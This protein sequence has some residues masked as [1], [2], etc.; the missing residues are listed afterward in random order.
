MILAASLLAYAGV[1]AMFAPAVLGRGTWSARAP[2][3]GIV[4]W[5]A[6]SVSAVLS[7]VLAGLTLAIPAAP[8]GTGL[9]ALLRSCLMALR[10]SYASPSGVGVPLAGLVLAGAVSIRSLACVCAGL[11]LAARDRRRHA[12]VLA[13]VGRRGDH[14]G[15]TVLDHATPG[16]YCLPGR[17]GQ[18]VLTSAA[19]DTLGKHQLDAVLAHE[20]AHLAGHHHLV[21]GAAEALHRAFPLVPLFRRSNEEVRRLVEMA[22]DDA[23]ARCQGRRPVAEAMAVL[24]EGRAPS[25]ALAAG[26]CG[27]LERVRRLLAPARPLALRARIAG[28][29]LA[30]GLLVVP[31][32]GAAAPALLASRSEVCP[33]SG[34]ARMPMSA[35]CQSW[36]HPLQAGAERGA[37]SLG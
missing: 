14:P 9:A 3:L 16:A 32:L 24:A 30:L 21:L 22:A 12:D 10:H 25:A 37:R 2:R 34:S 18:V 29:C 5:Q 33:M 23:A 1:L 4:I 6:L 36:S 7:A 8:F 20:R 19:L 11:S 31:A 17:H 27:A 13:L 26:G 15:A 28:F 35:P